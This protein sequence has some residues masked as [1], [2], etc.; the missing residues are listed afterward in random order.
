MRNKNVVMG[1][2]SAHTATASICSLRFRG[3]LDG[4]KSI[5]LTWA[6]TGRRGVV[7]SFETFDSLSFRDEDDNERDAEEKARPAS[8]VYVVYVIKMR[9]VALD[10]ADSVDDVRVSGTKRGPSVND[11]PMLGNCHKM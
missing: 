3:I 10:A 2:R 5:F 9:C 8:I 1:I 7:L 6:A 11:V 4:T